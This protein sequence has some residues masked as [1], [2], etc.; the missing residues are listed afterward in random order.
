M[1][2][3]AKSQTRS[4][5]LI[6]NL[7]LIIICVLRLVP[8]FGILITSFRPS[9]E[10]FRSGWWNVFPHRT[11]MEVGRIKLDSEVD[12]DSEITIQPANSTIEGRTPEGE[13]TEYSGDPIEGVSATFEEFSEGLT[14]DD[15]RTLLWSGNRRSRELRVYDRQWV[16]FDTKLTLKN[17]QDVITGKTIT[18]Q[19]A[20]GRTITR[21]GNDLGAAF[22]NSLAVSIPGTIIP[23]LIAAFAAFGF[24]WLNFP[25]RNIFFTII[26]ALLVVP[27]QI[28]LV[29]ILQDYV[30]MDLNG[31]F[32][33]IWLAHA[34]FGLPLATYLLF[35]YISNLPRELLESAFIDGASNFTIFVQLILPLSVPALASFAIFQFLWLWND[36]LVALIFLGERN[37]TVTIAVAQLVGEKGQ[38]WHLMTSAAFVSMILPLAVFLGLQRYFVRGLMAGS[39]KG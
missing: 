16:G 33:G 15:G 12:L 9:E 24:A 35:N 3:S 27:L 17:Y 13:T 29:P 23:I 19:D 2:K 18:Y 8:I 11:E 1:A 5:N 34:G 7:V 32:L 21:T 25:G 20:E 37:K 14:L 4:Q 39:V 30:K 6:V 31:T 36:Y 22:L 10:I 28:A 26:V 38:D